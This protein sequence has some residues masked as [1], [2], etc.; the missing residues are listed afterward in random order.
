MM[1]CNVC[2]V[3]MMAMEIKPIISEPWE[4]AE[5]EKVKAKYNASSVEDGGTWQRIATTTKAKAKAKI[6]EKD[7]KAKK[8]EMA[9][10]IPKDSEEKWAKEKEGRAPT[11]KMGCAGYAEKQGTSHTIAPS[12]KA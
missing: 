2:H 12:R 6:K 4:K 1:E 7:I 8:K 11:R 3:D 9:K 10:E 5:K